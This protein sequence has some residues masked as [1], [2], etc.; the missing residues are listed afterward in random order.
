MVGIDHWLGKT[1]LIVGGTGVN[2]V[3]VHSIDPLMRLAP[4]YLVE[5]CIH[6]NEFAAT[7]VHLLSTSSS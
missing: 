5:N 7:K 2:T 3:T 4:V 6:Q 1:V